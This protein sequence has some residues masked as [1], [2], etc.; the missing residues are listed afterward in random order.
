MSD[1]TLNHGHSGHET[2]F[3]HED[4]GTRGIFVFMIGLAVIGVVIYFIIV[5]MYSFLDRYERSQMTSASPLV[6]TKGAMSRVVTQ[7]DMD[8]TFKDN[9][10]PML[11]T[12]ERG[13]FKDFLIRQEEQLNS[14]GWVDQKDGV[15]HI[16]IERAM[17]LIVQHGLPVR[18]PSN[19]GGN[20][21]G[22]TTSA[23]TEPEKKGTG[24]PQ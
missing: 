15:A 23:S 21:G 3:E 2:E 13:Q 20:S 11:E 22:M 12:N 6:T 16:P 1:E 14:Y 19:P 8:K 9:G 4:L 17:D 18:A 10:A 7:A 24:A 5:G